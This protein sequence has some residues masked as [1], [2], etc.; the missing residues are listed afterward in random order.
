MKN[1]SNGFLDASQEVKDVGLL[2]C[3]HVQSMKGINKLVLN[4]LAQ[5]ENVNFN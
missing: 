3:L 2:R 1:V 5:M 4:F